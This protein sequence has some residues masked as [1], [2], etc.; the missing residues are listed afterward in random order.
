MLYRI[1]E[2][3]EIINGSDVIFYSN[4]A[5]TILD[6]ASC[7]IGKKYCFADN[8]FFFRPVPA[9]LLD[10]IPMERQVE[11]IRKACGYHSCSDLCKATQQII[12]SN[13]KSK[14]CLYGTSYTEKV[15]VCPYHASL[16]KPPEP[17][18]VEFDIEAKEQQLIF[19][20]DVDYA[21]MMKIPKGMERKR[22]H[23]RIETIE[24]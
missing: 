12:D 13:I 5:N 6:T 1:L 24:E 20:S 9:S 8:G 4:R 7:W 18:K 11:C 21:V 17:L 15:S 16:T 22:V 19:N 14:C 23:V 2:A 3:G 10:G